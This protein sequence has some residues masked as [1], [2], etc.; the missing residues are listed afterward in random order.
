MN[1]L[2]QGYLLELQS[3]IIVVNVVMSVVF[4]PFWF[5]L[6]NK[7]GV[8]M[9]PGLT[10]YYEVQVMSEGSPSVVDLYNILKLVVK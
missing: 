3:N 4:V 5:R 7:V 10:K 8:I 1:D 9:G 2:D 6:V